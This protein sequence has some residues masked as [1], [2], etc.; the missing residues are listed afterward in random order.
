MTAGVKP[1]RLSDGA[2]GWLSWWAKA[3]E[4]EVRGHE[5]ASNPASFADLYQE[6]PDAK[7][8]LS[9]RGRVEAK[10]LQ[11]VDGERSV[12][13]I[14]AD[15]RAT[16]DGLTEAEAVQLVVGALQGKTQKPKL[17]DVL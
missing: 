3:G 5:F 13:E 14:A 1:E 7:P 10:A 8:R 6:S 15:L 16:F 17:A 11:L 4:N 9:K 12:R 2:P